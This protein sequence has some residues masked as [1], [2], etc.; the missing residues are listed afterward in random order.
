ME[1]HAAAF[2]AAIQGTDSSH[3]DMPTGVPDCDGRLVRTEMRKP[4]RSLA[5]RWMV[6][7]PQRKVSSA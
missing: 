3:S 7:V 6:D 1:N 2:T 4:N 5:A